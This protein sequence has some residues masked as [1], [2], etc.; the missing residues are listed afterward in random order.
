MGSFLI[1]EYTAT[2]DLNSSTTTYSKTNYTKEEILSILEN[3]SYNVIPILKCSTEST[4]GLMSGV[5]FNTVKYP[6]KYF[7]NSGQEPTEYT[8]VFNEPCSNILFTIDNEGNL[9]SLDD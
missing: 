5:S 1:I 2:M 4:D 6:H 7:N 8:F 3:S 9:I